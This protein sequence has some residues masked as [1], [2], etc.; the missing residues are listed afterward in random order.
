METMRL[1]KFMAQ[2][3]AG[4]RRKCEEWILK[5]QVSVNGQIIEELGTRI[6]P[7]RDTVM[8]RGKRLKPEEERITVVLYKPE[9]YV[10]TSR[11]QFGRPHVTELVQIPGIRLYP[12]GRLDYQTTGVLLLTN[13]GD[14]AYQMTHPKHHMPKTYR[15]I[16]KGL[17]TEET[18]QKLKK[19]VV[20][21]DG[22]KTAPAQA[23]L[24]GPTGKHSRVEITV[25]EGKNHQVRRMA[26]AVGHP[27]LRLTRIRVGNIGLEG[28][29]EGQYRRLSADEVNTLKKGGLS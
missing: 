22:Y 18:L 14:L 11:D 7:K 19:G 17:V 29:K 25:Y 6:D 4:S 16:M 13:D 27:V 24:L 5:G 26:K 9:G 15:A 10:T 23:R 1:Q 20:L 8:F 28:L 12:V 3:G 21:D 2:A